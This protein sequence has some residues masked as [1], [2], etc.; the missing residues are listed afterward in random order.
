VRPARALVFDLDGTLADTRHDIAA[1]CNYTLRS[2]GRAP[3]GL[4]EIVGFVGD[5]SRTLVARCLDLPAH[6]PLVE[7][8]FATFSAY[9]ALHSADHVVW[10]PGA[11]AALYALTHVPWALATNKP[12]AATLPLLEAMG[13]ASRFVA[14]VAGGDGPLKPDPAAIHV[15]LATLGVAADDAW[16]IGDGP[17]DIGAG[18]AAG[19]WT[20]GVLGGFARESALR[21]AR[22]DRLIASLD[23]L[24]ALV[25]TVATGAA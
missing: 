13:L 24:P 3:K 17:Q 15:A 25:R 16:V 1:A 14:V 18:R 10:M 2:T 12:R 9:Y 20:V 7:A 19:T 21:D 6:D 8:A 11:R 5:G 4:D 22:P 23:A